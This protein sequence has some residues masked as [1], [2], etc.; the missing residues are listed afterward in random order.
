MGRAVSGWPVA[1][2]HHDF[3]T[4]A[5]TELD[6]T[7]TPCGQVLQNQ[8]VTGQVDGPNRRRFGILLF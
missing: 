6:V 4:E 8:L 1:G 5:L 3:K 7:L 2:H